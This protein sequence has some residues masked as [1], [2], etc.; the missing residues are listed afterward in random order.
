MPGTNV[1][2][3]LQ[4]RQDTNNNPTLADMYWPNTGDCGTVLNIAN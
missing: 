4:Q 2:L 1:M 3:K